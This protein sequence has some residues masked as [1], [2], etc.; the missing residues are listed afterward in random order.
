M[1]IAI[2][3]YILK[4]RNAITGYIRKY[5]SE[6]LWDC[7]VDK[8]CSYDELQLGSVH[9]TYQ[10]IFIDL[11]YSGPEGITCA[12]EIRKRDPEVIIVFF[13]DL[14]TYFQEG[15]KLG[16]R[17]YLVK[18]LEESSIRSAIRRSS[19]FICEINP[20]IEVSTENTTVKVLLKDIQ[21]IENAREVSVIHTNNFLI[22]TNSTLNELEQKIGNK[23]FLRSH[24][25]YL[26][27][28]DAVCRINEAAF[29]INNGDLVPIGFKEGYK[30]FE[31]YSA[32]NLEYINS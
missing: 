2:C 22:R 24:K 13:T 21:Y 32:C 7:H 3:D 17:N 28:L 6:Q 5:C 23:N 10:M 11:Y 18:P 4:D 8:Y 30:V 1:K 9:N 29:Q 27:N 14:E 31:R 16:V 12:W 25:F 15:Y 26:V 20:S 19:R